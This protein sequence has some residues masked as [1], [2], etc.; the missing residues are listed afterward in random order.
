MVKSLLAKMEDGK[1]VRIR[2]KNPYVGTK[3]D[4]HDA[5]GK[6]LADVEMDFDPKTKKIFS[7]TDRI[8][9][10]FDTDLKNLTYEKFLQKNPDPKTKMSLEEF[11]KFKSEMIRENTQFIADLRAGKISARHA[12]KSTALKVA[13][14]IA[15]F[16]LF[17]VEFHR[18]QTPGNMIEAVLEEV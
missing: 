14:H 11:E 6:I 9:Q 13:S 1:T 18:Q 2:L 17:A 4:F 8:L 15:L 3:T 12:L 10:A 7:P 16:P 5:I